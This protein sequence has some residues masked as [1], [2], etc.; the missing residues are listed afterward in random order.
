M[1]IDEELQQL[2][3]RLR[4]NEMSIEY[5]RDL[6]TVSNVVEAFKQLSSVH[7]GM[8]HVNQILHVD[9]EVTQDEINKGLFEPIQKGVSV[10]R[11]YPII[12]VWGEKD[13]IK[14]NKRLEGHGVSHIIQGHPKEIKDVISKLNS[15]L[16]REIPARPDK[17]GNYTIRVNQYRFV[18]TLKEKDNGTP[19]HAVLITAYKR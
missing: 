16:Q 15:S 2:S 5:G 17:Y 3:I 12:I 11:C 9:K 10:S 18:F 1:N 4:L 13:I 6:G 14:G 8:Y 19:D 7:E